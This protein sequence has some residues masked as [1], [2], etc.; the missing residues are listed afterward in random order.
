MFFGNNDWNGDGKIDM[1]DG[2]MDFVISHEVLG[3]PLDGKKK[4]EDDDD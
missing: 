4:N 3:I 2:V 1:Q